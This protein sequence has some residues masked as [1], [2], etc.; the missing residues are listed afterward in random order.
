MDYYRTLETEFTKSSGTFGVKDASNEKPIDVDLK[1][2][3]E[4]M[5]KSLN[6]FSIK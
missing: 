4:M 3:N 6:E 5:T 1:V 2:L